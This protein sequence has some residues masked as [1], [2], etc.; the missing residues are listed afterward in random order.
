[1][2]TRGFI[3]TTILSCCALFSWGTRPTAAGATSPAPTELS[4]PEQD[5][6]APQVAL[7]A[8]GPAVV[9]WTEAVQLGLPESADWGYR[10]Q[11]AIGS[12]QGAWQEPALI[13]APMLP[14]A[15]RSNS[16][17]AVDIQGNAVSLW[18]MNE[19]PAGIIEAAFRPAA[20]GV[21]SPAATISAPGEAAADARAAFDEQ[22]D[23]FVV[24]QRLDPGGSRVVADERRAKDGRWLSPVAISPAGRSAG[25]A[26]LAVDA[27]GDTIAAWSSGG[28]VEVAAS[29]A[30][31]NWQLLFSATQAP[32]SEPGDPAVAIGPYG[33]RLVAWESA[34]ER[35]GRQ[36][37]STVYAATGSSSGAWSTPAQ[38]SSPIPSVSPPALPPG[39]FARLGDFSP[40]AELDQWGNATVAWYHAVGGNSSARAAMRIGAEGSWQAPVELSAPGERVNSSPHVAADA[41]GNAIAVW[42]SEEAV[43]AAFRAQATAAWLA[44]VSL[45]TGREMPYLSQLAVNARGDA[46]VAW[47]EA[48]GG[49]SAIAFND[50]SIPAQATERPTISSVRFDHDRFRVAPRRRVRASTTRAPLGAQLSLTLSVWAKL[51]IVVTSPKASVRRRAACRARV[52]PNA[53][54]R[55][56]HPRTSRGKAERCTRLPLALSPA[57]LSIPG[58]TSLGFDGRVGNEALALRPGNYTAVLTAAN[59][60]GHS[61]VRVPFTIVR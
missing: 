4:P 32:S 18:R 35:P 13:S 53:R 2:R 10:L 41:L 57:F 6:R 50:S 20:T 14:P 3:I 61:S 55:T 60:A 30:G 27:Q 49:I 9:T 1:M 17:V 59:A 24:W 44:P 40:Q 11:S 31:A 51:S 5:G 47:Q 37:V 22:G 19:L 52:T 56:S 26:N 43:R 45:S 7:G 28:A 8:N 36:R 23:L 46:I 38:L 42:D 48:A 29:R 21:W 54:R 25:P 34:V 33:E 39:R 15:R 12:A 58:A 16:A